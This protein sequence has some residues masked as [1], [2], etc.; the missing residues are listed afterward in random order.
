MANELIAH[1]GPEGTER[2]VWRTSSTDVDAVVHPQYQ[3]GDFLPALKYQ[4]VKIGSPWY[5]KCAEDVNFLMMD[6]FWSDEAYDTRF[7]VPPGVVNYKYQHGTHVNAFMRRPSV[8]D[9]KVVIKYNDPLA[10]I[11]PLTER[12]VIVRHHLVPETERRNLRKPQV[13]FNGAYYLGRK[14]LMDEEKEEQCPMK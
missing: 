5:L 13:A 10:L 8:G 3:R 2:F 14:A 9:K 4:H 11:I 6:P 12:E 7:F 1:V